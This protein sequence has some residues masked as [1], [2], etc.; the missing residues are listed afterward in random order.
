MASPRHRSRAIIETCHIVAGED[1]PQLVAADAP[2]R[3]QRTS[4]ANCRALPVRRGNFRLAPPVM[5]SA[6]SGTV[7]A[8]P[9][10]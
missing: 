9:H 8:S 1:R 3:A 10:C 6:R 5:L 2:L 7:P 4:C